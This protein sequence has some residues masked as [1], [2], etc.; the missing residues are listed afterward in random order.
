VSKCIGTSQGG[1]VRYLHLIQGVRHVKYLPRNTKPNILT[2][3]LIDIHTCTRRMPFL[4]PFLFLS[5][6]ALLIISIN[7]HC[8]SRHICKAHRLDSIFNMCS[9]PSSYAHLHRLIVIVPRTL[10]DER[11]APAQEAHPETEWIDVPA[12]PCNTDTQREDEYYR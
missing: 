1:E 8:I 9:P 10:L 5:L 7:V 12:S 3:L 2:Y 6:T 4:A 11:S